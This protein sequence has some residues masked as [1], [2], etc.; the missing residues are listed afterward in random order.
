MV[1]KLINHI[2]RF[3][4]YE[5][6]IVDIFSKLGIKIDSIPK[7]NNTEHKKYQNY[8]TPKAASYIEKK[9]L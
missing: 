3:E 9:L 6:D 8:Y 4:N 2:G 1:K 5:D 7:E